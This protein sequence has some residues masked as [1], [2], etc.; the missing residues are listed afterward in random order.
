[1]LK[2]GIKQYF[3]IEINENAPLKN[4]ASIKLWR[5]S[6]RPTRRVELLKYKFFARFYDLVFK[7]FLKE[8]EEEFGL[9]TKTCGLVLPRSSFIMRLMDMPYGRRSEMRKM[10]SLQVGHMLPYDFEDIIFDFYVADKKGKGQATVALFVIT[11]QVMTKFTAPMRD[12]GIKPAFVSPST[13]LIATTYLSLIDDPAADVHILVDVDAEVAELVVLKGNN[14]VLTRNMNFVP[15]HTDEFVNQILVS[16]EK[17]ELGIAGCKVQYILFNQH[18]I[19]DAVSAQF[20]AKFPN[21]VVQIINYNSALNKMKIVKR[22]SG[23]SDDISLTLGVGL[24]LGK[25]VE[26]VDLLPDE[27]RREKVQELTFRTLCVTALLL[28][29]LCILLIAYFVSDYTL[30]TRFK[31]QITAAEDA[32]AAKIREANEVVDG[33]MVLNEVQIKKSLPLDVVNELYEIVPAGIFLTFLDYDVEDGVKVRGMA[34]QLSEVSDLVLQFQRSPYFHE[35]Q[36]KFA[37][38]R[39]ENG[40][41]FVDF[42]IDCLLIVGDENDEA[43]A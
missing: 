3:A 1:M 34:K 31:D 42:Q 40:E 30:K 12:L 2:K 22:A 27:I 23:L 33:I 25:L 37:K 4:E 32:I 26:S 6:E 38:K 35:V 15:G 29:V 16:L 43:I 20:R 5:V 17:E 14:I 7:E 36:M 24:V 8:A 28:I 39:I 13:P 9:S 19:F 11:K 18:K 10:V 21:S 41:E